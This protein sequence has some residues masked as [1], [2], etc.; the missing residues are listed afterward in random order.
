MSVGKLATALSIIFVVSV[1]ALVGE[2]LYVLWRHRSF[3]HHSTPNP[4][5]HSHHEN[6]NSSITEAAISKELLYF[7]CLKPHQELDPT[8][9]PNKD[10]DHE[11]SSND[12]ELDVFKLLDAKG[13]ARFLCTIKEEDKEEVESKPDVD[14]SNN[15]IT[16]SVCLA[17]NRDDGITK[18]VFSTPCDSPV[19]FTPAGSPSREFMESEFVV[20]VY[21]R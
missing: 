15:Q 8:G 20:S 7:F 10:K 12:Q 1:V 16:E 6:P 9:T 5:T 18:M 17:V 21:E 3:R 14:C 19:F 2:L 13:P 11:S 4:H